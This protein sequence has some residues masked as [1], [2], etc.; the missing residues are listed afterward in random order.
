MGQGSSFCGGFHYCVGFDVR[1]TNVRAKIGKDFTSSFSDA[2]CAAGNEYS[3]SG[4]S[5]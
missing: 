2:A 1:K 5:E 3:L 4:Q